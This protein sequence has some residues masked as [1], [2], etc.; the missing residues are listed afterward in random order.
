M[1]INKLY[2]RKAGIADIPDLQDLIKG[3]AAYEKR[4]QD[5]TG[6]KEQLH[7]W[8]FE[9]K[10]ATALLAE[11]NGITA[12][13]ALYYPVF[14]S[15]AA[16]GKAHLEDLFLKEDFRGMRKWNGAVLT[17]IRRLLTFIKKAEQSRKQEGYILH[18][19]SRGLRRLLHGDKLT[20]VQGYGRI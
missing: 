9:K 4:P 14:G 8:L 2:I 11:Y 6:T 13:Y 12:G 7:Y 18:L 1:D 20:E 16:A 17:G 15:F 3:L 19:T 5:M 10:I